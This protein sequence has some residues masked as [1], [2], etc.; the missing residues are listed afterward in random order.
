MGPNKYLIILE[1]WL[2]GSAHE[3]HVTF[4]YGEASE[5]YY[6]IG[7]RVYFGKDD[8]ARSDQ[9]CAVVPGVA[10]GVDPSSGQAVDR[11]Y[12]RIVFMNGHAVS[13]S[14][15][16]REDFDALEAEAAEARG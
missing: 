12:Y 14:L 8:V 4:A 16:T 5:R 9:F 7:D 2:D 15:T 10:T 11:R 13:C 1:P 6:R 3:I